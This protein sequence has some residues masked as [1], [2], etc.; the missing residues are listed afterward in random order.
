MAKKRPSKKAER[1][2]DIN[3]RDVHSRIHKIIGQCEGL[4]RM[5]DDEKSV[6]DIL[7]QVNAVKCALHR[8]GC[9][10]LARH[11]ADQIKSSAKTSNAAETAYKNTDTAIEFFCRMK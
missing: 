1:E 7:P 9:V 2:F 11:I 8:L 5:I 10:I 3:T 6:E 4:E